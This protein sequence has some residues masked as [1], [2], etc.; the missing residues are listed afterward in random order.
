[1]VVSK[2]KYSDL[3]V[4]KNLEQLK[5][6]G[7]L[8]LICLNKVSSE[9]ELLVDAARQRLGESGWSG[10]PV[11]DLPYVTNE[12]AFEALRDSK[13]VADL[14]QHTFDRSNRCEDEQ[15]F[16]GMRSLVEANWE[17]WLEPVRA[18]IT[19]VKHWR[20]QVDRE[21]HA[22]LVVYRERYLDH[23]GHYDAFN[24]A[25]LKLLELLEIPVVAAPLVRIRKV[26]TWPVK[27]LLAALKR[28]DGH[29][30]ALAEAT[31]LQ[32]IADH[33]LLSLKQDIVSANM[34]P[35]RADLWWRQMRQVYP[36]EAGALGRRWPTA[37]AAYQ[38]DFTPEIE[39][40]AQSLYARLQQNPVV[41]NTLRAT[42]VGADA[43]AV[44][45]AVKTGTVGVSEALL[46][47]AMLSLT[48]VLTEG[49]VGSYMET[50]RSELKDEQFNRVQTLFADELVAPLSAI[51]QKMSGAGLFDIDED[52]LEAMEVLK[53][54][55]LG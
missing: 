39:R 5:P 46:T 3:S 45:L 43:A 41:L 30:T 9:R 29:G 11:F 19:A 50:V 4:W 44:L 51:Q 10:V 53:T 7:R 28:R 27:T 13:Q 55:V 25:V 17:N 15:R 54:D 23:T 2:E 48:S 37:V 16:D 26:L 8:L 47:P 42:R 31:L 24:R 38:A 34:E 18:E 35:L 36:E 21:M 49:A 1:M 40:A 12:T 32:D 14:V 20:G 22:A 6:L 33:L 52:E